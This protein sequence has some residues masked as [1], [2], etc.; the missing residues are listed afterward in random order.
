VT[1]FHHQIRDALRRG[2]LA[3]PDPPE[4][5][6]CG[7]E[8][9]LIAYRDHGIVWICYFC[10]YRRWCKRTGRTVPKARTG[11]APP[12]RARRIRPNP[13]PRGPGRPRRLEAASNPGCSGF[14]TSRWGPCLN[15]GKHKGLDGRPYCTWHLPE[16]ENGDET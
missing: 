11:Q 14:S 2:E 9:R 5:G 4:C 15:D 3:Y 6:D 12:P 1:K 10:K 8:T 7:V 13:S 16:D